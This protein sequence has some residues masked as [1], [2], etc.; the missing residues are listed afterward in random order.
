MN[1]QAIPS[2]PSLMTSPVWGL[3]T[4]TPFTFTRSLPSFSV[5]EFDVGLAE[6]DEQIAFAGV[7]E[8]LGHVEVGVHAG[9]EHGDA[10]QAY[11]TPW[12]APR[13]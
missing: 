3:K 5:D 13:S 11:E 8:I 12:Y 4:S 7:L 1:Q 6:D 9:L 10:A 2:A